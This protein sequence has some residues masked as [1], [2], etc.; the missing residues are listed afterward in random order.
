MEWDKLYD[1]Y[2]E[3][4]YRTCTSGSARVPDGQSR[5]KNC[6][7][8]T[9][10]WSA[11][12]AWSGTLWM[13]LYVWLHLTTPKLR[14]LFLEIVRCKFHFLLFAWSPPVSEGLHTTI[15]FVFITSHAWYISSLKIYISFVTSFFKILE[16]EWYAILIN[17]IVN[18]LSIIVCMQVH[19]FHRNTLFFHSGRE[20]IS[21][22]EKS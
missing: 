7:R 12:Q 11:S 3:N 4:V 5:G 6:G 2:Q 14:S 21:H 13:I 19:H 1:V 20:V 9:G 22:K 17:E 16:C 18:S 15:G 8:D 10:H